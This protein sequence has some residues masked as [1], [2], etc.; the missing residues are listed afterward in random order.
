[1]DRTD[2]ASWLG[3]EALAKT[4]PDDHGVRMTADL[5]RWLL[6]EQQRLAVAAPPIMVQVLSKEVHDPSALPEGPTVT[7]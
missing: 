7:A 4:Y 5:A 1:M 6:Q 3:F 2:D